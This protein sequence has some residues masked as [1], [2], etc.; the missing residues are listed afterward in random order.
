MTQFEVFDRPKATSSVHSQGRQAGS[1]KACYCRS[2]N[3][4][5]FC[6]FCVLLFC[7]VIICWHYEFKFHL[8]FLFCSYRWNRHKILFAVLHWRRAKPSGA[9]AGEAGG[10]P[11]LH[12]TAKEECEHHLSVCSVVLCILF[13]LLCWWWFFVYIIYVFQ[14]YIHQNSN[15]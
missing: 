8:N 9:L 6:Y 5:V 7:Y 13:I 12:A 3:A 11:K 10:K 14:V 2:E 1:L 15:R 4:S